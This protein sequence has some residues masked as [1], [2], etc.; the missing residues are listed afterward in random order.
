[1]KIGQ[2]AE[3]LQVR[4]STLRFYERSGI[5][6]TRVGTRS[7]NNY[8]EYSQDDIGRLRLVLSLKSAGF[9]LEDVATLLR[10]GASDCGTLVVTAERQV[11]LV[12]QA[13]EELQKRKQALETLVADCQASC[14]PKNVLTSTDGLVTSTC[15]TKTY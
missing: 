7:A 13:I 11:K 5:L 10:P 1:M 8:R 12:G 4:P 15:V 9:R 2:V 6:G 14:D 3:E